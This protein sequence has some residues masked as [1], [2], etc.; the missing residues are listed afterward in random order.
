MFQAAPRTEAAL[1][2]AMRDERY[3]KTNHPQRYE[4]VGW[5]TRGWQRL[6][7]APPDG[8][9]DGDG[10]IHVRAHTRMRDCKI[11]EVEA[12]TRHGR[13]KRE[14]GPLFNA[15]EGKGGNQETQ[16]KQE[17]PPP[18]VIFIGGGFDSKSNILGRFLDDN[19]NALGAVSWVRVDH[20]Q[21]ADI[22]ELIAGAPE[23]TRIILVGHSWGADRAAQVAA[24]LGSQGRPI[25]T[26][27]TV[28]PV[29]RFISDDFMQRVRNGSKEWTNIRA[30]GGN[31]LESS[32]IVASIGGTYG[33][34]P[35]R[36]ASRTIEAPFTHGNFGELLRHMPPGGRSAWSMIRG[37]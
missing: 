18:L 32:N 27:V 8:D 29:G 13:S 35:D 12:H 15:D 1:R 21:Q 11:E 25:D 33:T 9:G 19:K 20:D 14:Q 28:D 23:G 5:V 34:A 17:L 22:L 6:E 3:W 2:E 4:Y 36:F 10:E 7:Q 37:R 31:A 16:D 24:L 30:T 26:L